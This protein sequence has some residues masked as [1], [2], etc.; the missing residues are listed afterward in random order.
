MLYEVLFIQ[1]CIELKIIYMKI[2]LQVAFVNVC[3]F[4]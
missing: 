2:Q 3:N 4:S 1:R